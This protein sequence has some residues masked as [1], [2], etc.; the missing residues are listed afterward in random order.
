M[1]LQSRDD[2]T[3]Y[4]LADDTEAV[5]AEPSVPYALGPSSGMQLHHALTKWNH[6][7][8][9]HDCMRVNI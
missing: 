5:Y 7:W 3:C 1:C 2:L 8:Y 4:V 6:N 9:S